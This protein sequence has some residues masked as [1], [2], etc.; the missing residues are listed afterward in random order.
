MKY[1][2]VI[3]F[4]FPNSLGDFELAVKDDSRIQSTYDICF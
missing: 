3:L 4:R 2:F 1:L